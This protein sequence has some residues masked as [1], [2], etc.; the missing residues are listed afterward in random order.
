MAKMTEHTIGIDI[1]KTHLDAFRL[2]DQT[3]RRFETSP[4]GIRALIR[5]LGQMPVACI[6]FE[7]IGPYHRA[8]KA[9]LSGK[10]PLVKVNPLQ[11]RRFAEACGT[12]AKTDLDD[13]RILVIHSNRE[14]QGLATTPWTFSR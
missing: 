3:A 2:E 11:A 10:L 8:L 9:A 6:V 1:S 7:S 5:W 12:R 4:R 13:G 14:T